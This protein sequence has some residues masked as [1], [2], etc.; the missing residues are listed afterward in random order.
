MNSAILWRPSAVVPIAMSVAALGLILGH[1]AL[2]GTARQA[3]EGS[4]AHL[5][6]LL[7]AG[8]VP[9]IAFFAIKSLPRT[10]RQAL[11][12]LALQVSAAVAAVAQVLILR[13]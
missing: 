9:I 5:W 2:V 12:V 1:I 4:E 8:Q 3:D 11:W 13:W 10:P 6:Q 7:I